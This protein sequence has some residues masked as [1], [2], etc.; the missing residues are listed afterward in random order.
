MAPDGSNRIAYGNA[1]DKN[2]IVRIS[3]ARGTNVN[4]LTTSGNNQFPIWSSDGTRVAF[5]STIGGDVAIYWQRA[6]RVGAPTRLTTPEAGTAHVPDSWHGDT[7]LFD[8]TKGSDWSLWIQGPG[9][10]PARPFNNVHAS[11]PTSATF[12]RDGRW[13]AY[14]LT[15]Q[16]RTTLKI[17]SFPPSATGQTYTYGASAD[18]G[19]S[20]KFAVWAPDGM[21]FYDPRP[22]DFEGINVFTR[23]ELHLGPPV[24]FP[25]KIQF[26]PPG[27]RT[28]Y[29]ITPDGRFVGLITAGA[30]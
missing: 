16:G 22:R 20:P 15:V 13:V 23:P 28:P 17:E 26:Y 21:L 3:N 2:G 5:Q 27:A 9:S 12:S 1:D 24:Q 8:V 30:Q 10:S 14:S 18:A 4:E 7:L 19:D 11:A 6:D 25:K 29:N